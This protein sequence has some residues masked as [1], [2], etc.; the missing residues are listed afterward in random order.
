MGR[1]RM[2][3]LVCLSLRSRSRANEPLS[4]CLL[5]SPKLLTHNEEEDTARRRSENE[6]DN[7]NSGMTSASSKFNVF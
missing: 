1:L 5:G 6:R 7:Q 4:R 2:G 3:E